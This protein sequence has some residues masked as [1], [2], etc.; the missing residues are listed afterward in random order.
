MAAAG[1]FA[2][3]T[4]PPPDELCMTCAK[5]IAPQPLQSGDYLGEDDIV[6]FDDVYNR[7]SSD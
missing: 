6:R 3:A 2:K 7:V 4:R 5:S 1:P